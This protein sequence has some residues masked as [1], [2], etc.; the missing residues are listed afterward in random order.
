VAM[1]DPIE[2]D[3]LVASINSRLKA[4]EDR[5]GVLEEVTTN[6]FNR[7]LDLKEQEDDK[8]T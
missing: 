4:L 1:P 3:K 5:V 2:L 7:L 6:E 8:C